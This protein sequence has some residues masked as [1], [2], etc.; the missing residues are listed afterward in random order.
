[1]ARTTE[2]GTTTPSTWVEE[3]AIPSNITVGVGATTEAV[4]EAISP[5]VEARVWE[6]AWVAQAVIMDMEVAI[7]TQA[8]RAT[9]RPAETTTREEEATTTRAVVVIKTVAAK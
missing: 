3:E 8:I 6:V 2:A 1:M 5:T 4:A 7:T 9:S